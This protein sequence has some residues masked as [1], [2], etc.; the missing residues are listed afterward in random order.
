MTQGH[1]ARELESMAIKYGKRFE[2]CPALSNGG[3]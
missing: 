1:V 2:P 3:W